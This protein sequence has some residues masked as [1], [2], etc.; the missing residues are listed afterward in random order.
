MDNKTIFV[1]TSKGEDQVQSRTSHLSGDVKRALSMVDGISSFGE[2][3]KRSAPSMR[4]NL[5]EMFEELE[6]SGLIQDK[7]FA[8]KIP[9]T[10]VPPQMVVPVKKVTGELDFI[11]RNAA[12]SRQAPTAVGKAEKLRAETEERS[13]RQIEAEKI[14]AQ[15]EAGAILRKAEEEAR[16]RLEAAERE[17]KE[18]EAARLKAEQEARRARDELEAAKRKVEQEARLR[19]EAAEKERKEAEAARL[20]AEQ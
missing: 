18:A 13:R 9:N 10:S 3:S 16:L 8:G 11:S 12:S 20:K 4:A 6:K 14:K 2:I 7:S 5:A 17:R 19:L 15:Q 1:R